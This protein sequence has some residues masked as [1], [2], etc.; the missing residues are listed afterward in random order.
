MRSLT[1]FVFAAALMLVIPATGPASQS[2]V[3]PDRLLDLD[4]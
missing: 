3:K 2:S 4:S 1:V